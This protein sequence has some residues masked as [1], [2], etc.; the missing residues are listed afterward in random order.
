MTLQRNYL[1]SI[2]QVHTGTTSTTL[3]AGTTYYIVANRL[4]IPTHIVPDFGSQITT[5]RG[6]LQLMYDTDI[7][8]DNL[9]NSYSGNHGGYSLAE[10]NLDYSTTNAL[11]WLKFPTSASDTLTFSQTDSTI[12]VSASEFTYL[13]YYITENDTLQIYGDS[14]ATSGTPNSV[15]VDGKVLLMKDNKIH[16]SMN[17][18]TLDNT[19]AA[20]GGGTYYFETSLIKNQTLHHGSASGSTACNQWTKEAQLGLTGYENNFGSDTSSEILSFFK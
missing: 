4:S 8:S 5:L 12:T 9:E 1:D 2:T 20:D 7:N 19:I 15:N 10:K 6:T 18:G 14:T 11:T 13:S 3:N 16:L 17:N